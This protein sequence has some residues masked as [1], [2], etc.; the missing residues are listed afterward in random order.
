MGR[1][2]P[3]HEAAERAETAR[4]QML[5]TEVQSAAVMNDLR[6]QRDVILKAKSNLTATGQ[7]MEDAKDLARAMRK[8]GCSTATT[9]WKGEGDVT[10]TRS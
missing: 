8:V 2:H 7:H 9:A 4:R 3:M 6:A 10:F 5:D 1:P